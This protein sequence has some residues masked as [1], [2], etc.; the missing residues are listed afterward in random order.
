[1]DSQ[2]SLFPVFIALSASSLWPDIWWGILEEIS[3]AFVIRDLSVWWNWSLLKEK[4]RER[5]VLWLTFSKRLEGTAVGASC[6]LLT[7]VIFAHIHGSSRTSGEQGHQS[8]CRCHPVRDTYP[9]PTLPAFPLLF[10]IPTPRFFPS[11][12]LQHL[13]VRLFSRSLVYHSFWAL[14]STKV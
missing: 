10:C 12:H 2:A 5:L 8:N 11:C 1:M 7:L 3:L 6:F 14:H 9:G 4:Q 13:G